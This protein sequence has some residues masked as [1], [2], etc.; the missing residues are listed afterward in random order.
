MVNTIRETHK[1]ITEAV[2]KVIKEFKA[3]VDIAVNKAYQIGRELKEKAKDFLD[4]SLV[5]VI[6][7][8]EELQK[9]FDELWKKAKNTDI[10]RCKTIGTTLLGLGNDA[11]HAMKGCLGNAV[12]LATQYVQSIVNKSKAIPTDVSGFSYEARMCFEGKKETKPSDAIEI[13]ECMKE[14]SNIINL[15]IINI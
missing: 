5:G 4:N 11:V 9:R 1:K 12:E 14:V 8:I 7:F 15:I 3:T 13:I 2:E 10:S 6:V